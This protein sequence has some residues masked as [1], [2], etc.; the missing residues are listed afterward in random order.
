[1]ACVHNKYY[2]YH[3]WSEKRLD[4]YS[5]KEKNE[6]SGK[7]QDEWKENSSLSINQYYNPNKMQL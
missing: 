5:E 4:L 7:K 2:I 6:N 1:M 3:N